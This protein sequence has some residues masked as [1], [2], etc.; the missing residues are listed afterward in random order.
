MM[1]RLMSLPVILGTLLLASVA[2]NLL[3]LL[4]TMSQL[5]G[6]Q[7]YLSLA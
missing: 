2:G 7:P 3:A 6:E 1:G 5:R 4:A